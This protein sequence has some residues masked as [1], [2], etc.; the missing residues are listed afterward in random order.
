[1]K[2]G[3]N[4]FSIGALMSILVLAGCSAT[5][6]GADVPVASYP[7]A[8]N[9]VFNEGTTMAKLAE[10]GSIRV[11]VKADLPGFGLKG[12]DGTLNGVD[13]DLA[14]MIAAKLG[15]TADTIEFIETPSKFRE[16]NILTGKVDMIVATYVINDA[17]EERVAFAGPY[18]PGGSGL[19]VRADSDITGIEDL[20]NPNMKVCTGI[21]SIESQ[22]IQPF[23]ADSAEQIVEF[24]SH[25]KCTE[26]LKNGQVD[27]MAMTDATLLGLDA[28]NPGLYK[29][30]GENFHEANFGVGIQHGDTEFCQFIEDVIVEAFDSGAYEEAWLRAGLSSEKVPELPEQMPCK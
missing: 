1:M 8:E 28:E 2:I 13:I 16:E 26:A 7:V 29:I 12:L 20:N 25:T 30:V 19:M 21:G 18:Y 14:K 17:R 23:L 22:F 15:I 11:G 6:A 5:D 10:N 4:I 9:P 27:V 24:D 3:K